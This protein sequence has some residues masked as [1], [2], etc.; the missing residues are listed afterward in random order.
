MF[1]STN[2]ETQSL[3]EPEP[4]QG[5]RYAESPGWQD[6]RSRRINAVDLENRLGDRF[7][8]ALPSN[9]RS[10]PLMEGVFYI[11]SLREGMSLHCTDIVHLQAMTTRTVMQDKCVKIMLRLEGGARVRMGDCC[12]PLDAGDRPCA[13]PKGL[14][15]CLNA[16]EEFERQCEA[17]TRQRMVVVTLS[18]H[19]FESAALCRLYSAEHL[20]I[21]HWVPTPRAIAV[22]EQLIHPAA[23]GEGLLN[24]YLESR[25]LELVTEAFSQITAG[26]EAFPPRLRPG[27]YKRIRTLRELLDSGQADHLNMAAIAREMGCNA[28]T[29]QQ[30]FGFAFGQ[31]IFEYLRESRLR[32]AA[33]ALQQGGVSVAQAAEIAGYGSQ[34]NFSTAFRRHFGVP[35]KAYRAR[36]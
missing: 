17:G 8:L 10:S 20:S 33:V 18:P 27:D 15:V 4:V 11:R 35:P 1:D 7:Q 12:L 14:V 16:P 29:L 9:D 6:E 24:L 5:P 31:T 22:A 19:W 21:R 23:V 2:L 3:L 34:A 26:G 13:C 25:V 28:T 32:R 36:L 30:Q